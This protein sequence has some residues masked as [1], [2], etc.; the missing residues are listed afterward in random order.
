[1]K[2]IQRSHEHLGIPQM[3]G[4][5]DP[6]GLSC[7]FRLITS[8]EAWQLPWQQ[9]PV[10]VEIR[11]GSNLMVFIIWQTQLRHVLCLGLISTVSNWISGSASTLVTSNHSCHP[12]PGKP[13]SGALRRLLLLRFSS[14]HRVRASNGIISKQIT[15]VTPKYFT[16]TIQHL[17]S[18]FHISWPCLWFCFC[19]NIAM[20]TDMLTFSSAFCCCATTE[21]MSRPINSNIVTCCVCSF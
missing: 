5:G 11:P 21:Q 18:E 13:P 8:T 14:Y 1:M 9:V 19:P 2:I 15:L 10:S 6:D 12:D 17:M 20:T 7:C 4:E 16:G 3:E